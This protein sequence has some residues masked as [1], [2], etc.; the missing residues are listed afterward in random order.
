MRKAFPVEE[1]VDTHLYADELDRMMLDALCAV[2]GRDI[3]YITFHDFSEATMMSL[4]SMMEYAQH[5]GEAKGRVSFVCA[6]SYAFLFNFPRMWSFLLNI[7]RVGSGFDFHWEIV[8]G[9]S[10]RENANITALI[11][12]AL[13]PKAIGGNAVSIDEDGREDETYTRG[14]GHARVSAMLKRLGGVGVGEDGGGGHVE[15][16][17][18]AQL[19]QI[20]DAPYLGKRV[21]TRGKMSNPLH[22]DAGSQV[23][24]ALEMQK[25][26]AYGAG[27]GGDRDDDEEGGH[28]DDDDD[29]DDDDNGEDDDGEDDDEDDDNNNDQEAGYEIVTAKELHKMAADGAHDENEGDDSNNDQEASYEIVTAEEL[30]K[31]AAAGAR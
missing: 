20:M 12:V 11:D 1:Y 28:D 19:E 24:T 27:D 13:L 4:L 25:V 14:V 29:D 23:I 22:E 8:A 9:L 30:Q 3:S 5:L 16:I 15:I 21:I 10:L 26:A 7:I 17:N 6:Q 18:T 2:Q 31:M